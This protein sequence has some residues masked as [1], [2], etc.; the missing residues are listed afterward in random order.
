MFCAVPSS[1]ALT[2][3][4][5]SLAGRYGN[6]CFLWLCLLLIAALPSVVN[7]KKKLENTVKD[8]HYG[9]VLYEVFQDNYFPALTELLIGEQQNRLQHHRDFARVLRGGLHLS[10]GMDIE[11]EALFRDVIDEHPNAENRARA[12]FYLGKLL[13]KKSDY[14]RASD[15][16]A[17]VDESLTFDLHDEY[18]F[19][20]SALTLHIGATDSGESVFEPHRTNY[21]V[22]RYYTDY[23]AIIGSLPSAAN[24]QLDTN[25]NGVAVQGVAVQDIAVQNAA[26]AMLALGEQISQSHNRRFGAELLEL[27]DRVYTT[28]GYLHMQAGNVDSAINSFTQVRQDGVLVGQALLG[29]GWAA[30]NAGDYERAL[31]PWQVLQSRSMLEA[32]THEALLAVPFLYEKL[33]AYA[34]AMA[35]YDGALQ[36]LSNELLVL[37]DLSVLLASSK[38]PVLSTEQVKGASLWLEDSDIVGEGLP[39]TVR[40]HFSGLLAQNHTRKL[41]TQLNDVEWLHDNLNSWGSSLDTLAFAVEARKVRSEQAVSDASREVLEERLQ[42]VEQQRNA[43]SEKLVDAEQM[44]DPIALLNSEEIPLWLRLQKARLLLDSIENQRQTMV[45]INAEKTSAVV[46]ADRLIAQREKLARLEGVLR[47][48][49]SQA[50]PARLWE[51]KK[52]LTAIDQTLTEGRERLQA[53]SV[54]VEQQQAQHGNHQRLADE[55]QRIATQQAHISALRTQIHG[56]LAQ[57]LETEVEKLRTRTVAYIGQARL[58]RARLLDTV[59]LQAGALPEQAIDAVGGAL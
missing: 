2:C 26:N 24:T 51:S 29:F 17:K 13:Y 11:A 5:Y 46:A 52:Q 3:R 47:W 15:A 50:M 10:Y 31:V 28:A 27:R 14:A 25:Q 19:I 40:D 57:L 55:R 38:L 1:R 34:E 39:A 37:D 43:L 41:L 35:G 53:F 8:L 44:A 42:A 22:W 4:R 59:S 54:L 9:V 23:N 48:K 21:S 18:A 7:A 6:A 16:F 12:W 20:K 36:R 30:V 45:V 56:A 58:A 32:S 33:G 49:A